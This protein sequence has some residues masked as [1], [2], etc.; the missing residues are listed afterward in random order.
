MTQRQ[1]AS[2][3]LNDAKLER[4]E[5]AI[6]AIYGLT[7]IQQEK[8]PL[9]FQAR[10]QGVIINVWKNTRNLSAKVYLQGADSPL[11]KM[12]IEEIWLQ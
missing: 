10:Y 7:L 9:H 1:Y 5:N 12:L 6:L 3:T 8:A 4:F 2:R 11:L